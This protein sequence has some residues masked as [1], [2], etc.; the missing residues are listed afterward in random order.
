MFGSKEPPQGEE[1]EVEQVVMIDGV[2]PEV[3]QLFLTFLYTGS[4]KDDEWKEGMEM[5]RISELVSMA[6]KV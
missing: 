6:H 3:V 2:S 1:V 5:G 4:M